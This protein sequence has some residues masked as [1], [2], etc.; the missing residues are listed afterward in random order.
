[1]EETHNYTSAMNEFAFMKLYFKVRPCS[2]THSAVQH[3]PLPS[4]DWLNTHSGQVLRLDC[5]TSLRA[6]LSE[7]AFKLWYLDVVSNQT[8]D[9]LLTAALKP[10]KDEVTILLHLN[11]D[12]ETGKD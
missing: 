2:L 1:M 10:M 3:Y 7:T 9:V 11:T 6:Q 5:S 12:T 4:H 8:G